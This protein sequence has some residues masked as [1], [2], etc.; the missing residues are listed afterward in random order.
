MKYLFLPAL[1]LVL[2]ISSC[3]T[4]KNMDTKSNPF[5]LEAN[6]KALTAQKWEIEKIFGRDI[7][8]PEGRDEPTL[9]FN[10]DGTVTGHT[11]CNPINGTYTLEEGLRIK[12][13]NMATGL[14]L[15]SDVP[16]EREFL[17]ILNTAD[18]YT[19]ADGMLS[20]NKARMAPMAVFERD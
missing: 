13:N 14:A 10:M 15:C 16:Y 20:L 6:R 11:G 9:K 8:A 1:L 17:D 4:T 7:E 5:D 19:I 12:F 3:N 18:N 2:L